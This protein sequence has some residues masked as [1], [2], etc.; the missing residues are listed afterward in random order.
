MTIKI[1]RA[2]NFCLQKEKQAT[3]K[4]S[5]KMWCGFKKFFAYSHVGL[6]LLPALVGLVALRAIGRFR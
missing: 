3:N 2:A 5:R 4:V 6:P 1:G